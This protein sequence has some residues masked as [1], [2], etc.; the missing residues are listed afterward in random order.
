M[1]KKRCIVFN[2]T[3]KKKKQKAANNEQDR[4]RY[5]MKIKRI[6]AIYAAILFYLFFFG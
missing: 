1:K 4:K 5:H 6:T 3:N 2:A